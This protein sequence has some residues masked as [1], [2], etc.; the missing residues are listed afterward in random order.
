MLQV[1]NSQMQNETGTTT[2]NR[3]CTLL[4]WN[5]YTRVIFEINQIDVQESTAKT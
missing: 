2:S 1:M 4:Y 3:I 5:E